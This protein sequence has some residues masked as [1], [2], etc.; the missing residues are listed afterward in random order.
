MYV[1]YFLNFE[2][3]GTNQLLVHAGDATL[4]DKT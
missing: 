3:N 1:H 2:V 4:L